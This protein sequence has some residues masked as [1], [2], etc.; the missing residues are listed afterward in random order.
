M[1]SRTWFVMCSVAVCGC[2]AEP[3]ATPT[4]LN[5]T[6]A[7]AGILASPAPGGVFATES[8]PSAIPVAAPPAQQNP[9]AAPPAAPA[10]VDVAS[11]VDVDA[12][13]ANPEPPAAGGGWPGF[14]RSGRSTM[15]PADVTAQEEPVDITG[16][17]DVQTDLEES[18]SAAAAPAPLTFDAGSGELQPDG[19]TVIFRIADGTGG[20]DWNSE[21]DPIRIRRGMVLHLIDEDK[22]TR[23]GGHQLHTYGQPCPHSNRK[24][25][26]GYDCIISERAP[27]GIQ[28]GV[29]EH[30][31]FNG[32]GYLYIEVVENE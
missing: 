11:A 17:E 19:N 13:P 9:V 18:G 1:S 21:D 2:Q 5:G 12:A 22:S 15:D 23:N 7:T 20:N 26:D 28:D 3:Q 6:V 14:G 30:N 27:L 32:I 31:I 10:A 29:A 25:G 4:P 8:A 16:Q 24:I